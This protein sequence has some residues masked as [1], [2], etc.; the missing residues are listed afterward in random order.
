MG[1]AATVDEVLPRATELQDPAVANVDQ[2]LLVFALERPA[3]DLKGATRQVSSL[4]HAQH[5]NDV[6]H[7]PDSSNHVGTQGIC[8]RHSPL[9]SHRGRSMAEYK[10]GPCICRFLV[11]AEAAELPVAV[12]LNKAD[13]VPQHQCDEAVREVWGLLRADLLCHHTLCHAEGLLDQ[14]TPPAAE[15]YPA[16]LEPEHD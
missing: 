16:H 9:L 13:L 7:V 3:L 4:W 10:D 6:S 5:G 14:I 8:L 1:C 15:R 12:V 2:V 11:S